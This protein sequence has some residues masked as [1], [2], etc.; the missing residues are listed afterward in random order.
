MDGSG[1]SFG[2][3]DR[4]GQ[5]EVLGMVLL[6]GM[7][8]VAAGLV[9]ALGATAIDNS[10]QMVGAGSAEQSMT[11]FDSEASLVGL[12][13]TASKRVSL[14]TST[15]DE[16][17]HVEDTAG[18]MNVSVVNQS[19]PTEVE[20][21][22]L[23]RSL[24][25][26]VYESEEATVAYQGG[27]VW[28]LSGSGAT[29]V[30]PP[31]VHYRAD[32]D[33]GKPTLTLPLVLVD[34]NGTVGGDVLLRRNGSAEA[35]YPDD[36]RNLANP[37][38]GGQV[39]VTVNS[40][41]YRAWGR[42]F[43]E[44]TG[45]TVVYDDSK[46]TVTLTL[47]VPSSPAPNVTT[48]LT[49][50]TPNGLTIAGTGPTA[51][52][53]D[54]YNSS[55]APHPGSPTTPYNGTIRTRG[56]VTLTGGADIYGNVV[57]AGQADIGSGTVYGNLSY[58][59]GSCGGGCRSSVDGWTAKNASVP[60][61]DPIGGL[62][63]DEV[64]TLSDP[65][66]NDNGPGQGIDSSNQW[67]SG[68]V[69]LTAGSYYVGGTT[70]LGGKTVTFDT[71]GGDITLAIDGDLKLDGTT[72][73]VTD[74]EDGAVRVYMAGNTLSMRGATVGDPVTCRAPAFRIYAPPGLDITMRQGGGG[75]GGS[76][77]C[78]GGGGPGPSGTNFVGMVYAPG[79]GA[80][81]PSISIKNPG[82][83][84]YGAIVAS[85]TTEIQAGAQFHYDE[86]LSTISAPSSGGG[87]TAPPVTYIHVSVSRLNVTEA[88]DG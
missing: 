24:G 7:T 71:S 70:D 44:R 8:M 85:G 61:I 57:T 51:G 10:Q 9:L 69:T 37:I 4:R 52:F 67:E 23:N 45:G 34:G 25:A 82:T 18:W 41:F 14:S 5:S 72:F 76:H 35:R 39:N 22:V 36:S 81:S 75:G 1:G 83:D 78:A 84:V 47:V 21:V 43:E 88:G 50:N 3:G 79:D 28:R 59:V 30:S 80:A 20:T 33:G 63:A 19:T 40:R 2:T 87:R 86:A 11:K 54:S 60:T 53:T 46:R 73:N 64:S 58:G 38:T 26:V 74:P 12:G 16:S 31:E 68:D 29:M 55:M 17:V 66:N 77:P 62:V 32:R 48:A 49:L 6:L 42:F 56:D 13:G 65:A 27:G 15:D